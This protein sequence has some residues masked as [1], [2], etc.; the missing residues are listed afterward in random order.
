MNSL[1]ERFNWDTKS[2]QVRFEDATEPA[3]DDYAISAKGVELFYAPWLPPCGR[4][5]PMLRICFPSDN[6]GCNP[7]GSI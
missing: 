2:R 1:T 6:S 4:M 5:L 7:P 3:T